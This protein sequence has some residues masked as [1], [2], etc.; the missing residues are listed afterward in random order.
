MVALPVIMGLLVAV[1]LLGG[2]GGESAEQTAPEEA[3]PVVSQSGEAVVAEAVVEPARWVELRFDV[4]GEIAEVLVS[5]EDRVAANASLLRLDTK[6]LELSLQ[7]AR[8]DVVAQRA[9]LA[10]LVKGTRDKVIARADKDN[11]DQIVQAEIA[12]RAA[13]LRLENARADDPAAAVAAARARVSQL[14]SRLVQSRVQGSPTSLAAAQIGLERAKIALDDTQDEY[15]KA[16][17]RPWEDQSIRDEWAKRL[18]QVQLDHELAQARL[19][20]ALSAQRAHYVGLDAM[21][22]Q[23]QEA[24]AQL[25]QAIA[26]QETFTRTLDVLAVDVEAA[27]A[28]LEALRTWDNPLLDEA[29]DEQIAQAEVRLRQAE[30]AVDRLALQIEDA[31]LQAPFAGTVVE[32][33]VEVGERV[34]PNQIVVVLA[35]LDQLEV[36]TTDLTELDVGQVVVGQPAEVSVDALPGET[37]PGVVQA[38]GLRGEDYRGDVVYEV[39]VVLTDPE[40]AKALRWGM[41]AVVEIKAR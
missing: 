28:H 4:G 26:A 41:T 21:A 35:T 18:E 36:N 22:A 12:L 34:S 33:D 20:S 24:E 13:E 23:V 15:T 29:T 19:D 31:E 30:V 11:S 40:E 27:R 5:E 3:V 6:Q 14:Q 38:I 16:L 17:D 2:C 7:S 9:A 37:Y 1:I 39:T 25:A 10:E 32:V 8:Q